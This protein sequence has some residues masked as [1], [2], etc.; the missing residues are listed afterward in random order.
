MAPIAGAD[1]K[2]AIKAGFSKARYT[3]LEVVTTLYVP[4][5]TVEAKWAVFWVELT[6]AAL[7]WVFRWV[8]VE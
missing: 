3:L 1:K 5:T 8:L 6:Y 7:P 4:A 2:P